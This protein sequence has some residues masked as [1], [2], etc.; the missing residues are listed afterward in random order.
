MARITMSNVRLYVGLYNTAIANSV[1]DV[2]RECVP[3]IA[4]RSQCGV[5]NIEYVYTN[6]CI[7]CGLTTREAYETVH[8]MFNAL[9]IL[10]RRLDNISR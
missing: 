7:A 8:A 1:H 2:V 5:H 9:E 4:I 3:P 6:E 10:E